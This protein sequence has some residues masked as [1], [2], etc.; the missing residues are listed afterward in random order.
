MKNL[1]M[2]GSQ[3]LSLG[4]QKYVNGGVVITGVAILGMAC[5]AAFL[6]GVAIGIILYHK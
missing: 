1:E 5:G 2:F 6:N 3:E 4:E